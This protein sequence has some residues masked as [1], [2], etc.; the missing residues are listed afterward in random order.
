MIYLLEDMNMNN[1]KQFSLRKLL[2]FFGGVLFQVVI[3]LVLPQVLSA[4]FSVD[5]WETLILLG[6][7]IV[8]GIISWLCISG[9]LYII[10]KEKDSLTDNDVQGVYNELEISKHERCYKYVDVCSISRA[11]NRPGLKIEMDPV[12]H[13][14]RYRLVTPDKI[15]SALKSAKEIHVISD[16]FN[17]LNN[18]E[19]EMIQ[20]LIEEVNRGMICHEHY[21]S[22]AAHEPELD[23]TISQITSQI[24]PQY[25]KNIDFT[26]FE[27]ISDNNILGKSLLS[28]VK[29]ILI[30]KQSDN[31]GFYSEGYIMYY[32][33]IGEETVYYRLPHC[34]LHAFAEY[35]LK[36]NGSK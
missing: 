26:Q 6:I 36:D 4:I 31:Q 21:V 14:E 28:F 5:V 20:A 3:M 30:S 17:D 13:I 7:L 8:M 11:L 15:K 34:N 29:I 23:Q 16:Q 12:K 33:V 19:D 22:Y 24:K 27:K 18:V 25:R 2:I 10:N 35:F 1:Q 9:F 32:S